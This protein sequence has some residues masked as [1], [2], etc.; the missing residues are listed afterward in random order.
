MILCG[1]NTLFPKTASKLPKRVSQ[2]RIIKTLDIRF[3]LIENSFEAILISPHKV[4][5]DSMSHRT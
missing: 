4:K 1:K 3:C 5:P 2:N